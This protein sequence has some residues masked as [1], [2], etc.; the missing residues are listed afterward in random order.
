MTGVMLR[1]CGF[2]WDLRKTSPYETY[3]DLYFNIP[4]GIKADNFDRYNI[5]LN[6]MRESLKIIY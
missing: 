3:P 5:R 4:V 1:S 6:E 2:N